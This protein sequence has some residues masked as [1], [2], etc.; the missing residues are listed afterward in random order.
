[1]VLDTISLERIK[2]EAKK[3]TRRRRRTQIVPIQE[4]PQATQLL[5]KMFFSTDNNFLALVEKNKRKK[6]MTLIIKQ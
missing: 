4:L 1:V 2:M 3:K 5:S 6:G